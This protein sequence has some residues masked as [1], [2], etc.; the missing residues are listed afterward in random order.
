ML[1]PPPRAMPS[2]P[3]WATLKGFGLESTSRAHFPQG[4]LHQVVLSV[5]LISFESAQLWHCCFVSLLLCTSQDVA[6]AT[7]ILP[8]DA[9]G[10]ACVGWECGALP[11]QHS[12]CLLS[13]CAGGGTRPGPGRQVRGEL[14]RKELEVFSRHF[15]SSPELLNT[16]LCSQWGGGTGRAHYRAGNGSQPQHGGAS[17]DP[18]VGHAALGKGDVFCAA[19]LGCVE[20]SLARKVLGGGACELV[21]AAE[22]GGGNEAQQMKVL[23]GFGML[24]AS[25][26][27]GTPL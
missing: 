26:L 8:G 15:K 20:L 1:P 6:L 5:A 14:I 23:N 16:L 12:L 7:S 11:V 25:C 24:G 27:A 17:T 22:L 18:T 2:P 4:T 10:A 19:D 21:V 3:A 13:I 9:H